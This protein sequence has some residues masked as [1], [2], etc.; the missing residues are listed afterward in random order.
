[1]FFLTKGEN[2]YVTHIRSDKNVLSIM[3]NFIKLV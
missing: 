3:I 1:V 2:E